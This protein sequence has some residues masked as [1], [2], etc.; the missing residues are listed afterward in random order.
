MNITVQQILLILAARYKVALAV[1]VVT[2]AITLGITSLLPKQYTTT[3]TV[4]VD[5]RSPDPIATVMM[6]SGMIPQL[7]MA[8]QLDIIKSERVARRV[9]KMLKLDE[10]EQVK[11]QWLEDTKGRGKLDAWL[12][13]LFLKKLTAKQPARESSIIN[14]TFEATDPGFA[15]AVANAF[16]QAYIDVN[17]ELKVEPAKQYTNWFALQS[18]LLRESLERAQTKFSQFQREK[19]IVAKDEQMDIETARLSALSTLLNTA[20]GQTTDAF[21]KQNAADTLP[22]IAS[23]PAILSLKSDINRHQAKL[24]EA[25]VN[26]GKNHPQYQRMETELA[27]FR[28]QLQIETR[29]V[30]TGFSTSRGVGKD[31][32]AELRAAIEAQKKKLLQ[33]KVERDELAVLQRDV[34]AAKKAF[35][36]VADRLNQASLDSQAN[37][38]NVSVLTQA[39]API[40]PSFPKMSVFVLLALAAGAVLGVAAACLPEML[41]RRIRSAED[42]AELP[43]SPVL[44][45]LERPRVRGRRPFPWRR[46]TALAVK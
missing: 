1:M 28:E 12:A 8:T 6:H 13:P 42:L 15:E 22:E 4:I 10:D 17:I 36:A 37:Q 11:Q 19:G 16:A 27:A 30:I 25:A 14:I 3:A 43:Q 31:K 40:E 21:I 24:Q 5:S 33:I 39:V 34:D 46:R 7:S 38:T 9:V 20:Q 23:H 2:I 44:G 32:E 29:R 41:D 26:L 18:Q 35:E 45:V